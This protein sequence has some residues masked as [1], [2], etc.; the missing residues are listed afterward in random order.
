MF[1]LVG[2][3]GNF[4]NLTSGS[5]GFFEISFRCNRSFKDE[6]GGAA[7]LSFEFL[8]LTGLVFVNFVELHTWTW[9]SEAF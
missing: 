1:V 9:T 8:H 5:S 4:S 6:S 7:M 2:I 3:F